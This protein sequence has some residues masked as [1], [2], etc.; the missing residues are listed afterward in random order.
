MGGARQ[1]PTPPPLMVPL[2]PVVWCVGCLWECAYN[3]T[4]KSLQPALVGAR[5]VGCARSEH[6]TCGARKELGLF[7]QEE[8]IYIKENP[9]PIAPPWPRASGAPAPAA[10]RRRGTGLSPAAP[11]APP[12]SRAR[13]HYQ[14]EGVKQLQ[15]R[16][17]QP[18]GKSATVRATQVRA[19]VSPHAHGK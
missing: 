5:V 4:K 6:G 12:R 19:S 13:I 18:P 17:R 10:R 14:P 15:P 9:T 11:A 2:P 3:E 7:I 1:P 8:K 16:R